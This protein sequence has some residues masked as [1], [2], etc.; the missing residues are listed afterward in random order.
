MCT[1]FLFSEL[2]KM[3]EGSSNLFL[4]SS[5]PLIT[6]KIHPVVIFTILDHYV[7][8]S[9]SQERVIGT[10]LGV[11]TDGVVEIRNC[12]PVPHSEESQV[13]FL[14]IFFFQLDEKIKV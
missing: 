12:F 11:E 13:K 3:T 7:R 8:R 6:C 2:K 14:M 9:E 4:S 10:L 5:L 1:F